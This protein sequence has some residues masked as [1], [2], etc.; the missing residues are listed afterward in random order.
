MRGA[1][2][3][4][5]GLSPPMAEAERDIKCFL[6]ANMYRHEKVTGVWE[7]ARDAISRLFPA[8]FEIRR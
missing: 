5:I 6:F 1:G 8:F 2:E 4:L 3:P 7:S